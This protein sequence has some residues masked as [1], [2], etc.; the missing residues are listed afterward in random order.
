MTQVEKTEAAIKWA[1]SNGLAGNPVTPGLL[2]ISRN[3]AAKL[4]RIV[5]ECNYATSTMAR[6]SLPHTIKQIIEADA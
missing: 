3:L 5:L 1:M 2:E 6:C 4:D